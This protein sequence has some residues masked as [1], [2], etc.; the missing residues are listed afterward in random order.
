MLFDTLGPRQNDR[1]L[2]DDIF[3]CALF[4]ENLSN[5]PVQV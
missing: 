3:K 1:N 4:N 5:K 2:E